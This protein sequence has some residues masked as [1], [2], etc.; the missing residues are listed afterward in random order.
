MSS[1]Q[2][3]N[4]P[5]AFVTGASY[6][7]G[8]ATAAAFA[9]AGYDVVV[10][11]LSADMLIDTI[12]GIEALGRRGLAV[13][14]D[15]RDDASI[16][17]AVDTTLAAFG[18][19]DVLVNNAGVQMKKPAL[20]VSRHDFNRVMDVNLTGEF[21]MSCAVARHWINAKQPGVIVSV[22]STHG[23]QGVPDS[24][25]YGISKAGIAHMTRML[26]VEWAKHGIRVNAIAPA[27]TETPTRKGL[28]D[29]EKRPGMLARFPLGRFGQPDDMAEAI[30]FL[31]AP[32][33]SFVTGHILVV[34]G[35]LTAK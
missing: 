30:A 18:R 16:A 20:E 15:L 26:A 23:I 31:A 28:L 33:A 2:N 10:G 25:T 24:S 34:D 1:S 22:A 3:N 11:D 32:K 19:I 5:V 4:T 13:A 12:S 35:G 8:A 6:G 14:L 21:L 29:P 7:I 27:S 9:R 17:A